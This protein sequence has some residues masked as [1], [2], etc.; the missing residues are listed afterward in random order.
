MRRRETYATSGTRPLVRFFAAASFPEQLCSDPQG[1]EK[2]YTDG[3]PMGGE[4]PAP[5][6]SPTF[7][8]S[9]AKDPGSR[10]HDGVELQRIQIVKGWLDVKGQTHEQV[11][12]V[13][14]TA[15]NN[16]GVDPD[17]CA[18]TGP[19][20]ETLCT[21]WR[22]PG[23]NAEQPAF[24]YARVLENPSCRWSTRHCQ[25]AGVNPFAPDCAEQAAAKTA[26]LQEQGAIGDVYGKCC[27]DPSSQPFYSPTLQERAWTSPIWIN[28]LP[29]NED[30]R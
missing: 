17:T 14:G 11:F 20:H 26:E 24:Y 6:N 12:D 8:V 30:S 5:D 13:A 1:I 23:Y 21:V 9:A 19:G 28:P 16:A 15:D 7:L 10:G 4:M 22:D 18:P 2:A 25:A 3:V 27:L 29:N